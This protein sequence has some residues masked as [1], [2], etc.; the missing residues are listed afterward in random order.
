[1]FDV[2]VVIKIAV[3]L[4]LY[5]AGVLFWFSDTFAGIFGLSGFGRFMAGL[6]CIIIGGLITYFGFKE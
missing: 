5:I 2:T 4:G 6:V 3:D 1:M